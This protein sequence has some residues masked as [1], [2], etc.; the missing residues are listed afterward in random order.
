[1][2]KFLVLILLFAA[3][4]S[5]AQNSLYTKDTL[6]VNPV[7]RQRVKS[8]TIIAANQLAADTSQVSYLLSY[9]NQIIVNP[10]GGWISTMTY[11]VTSNP[12]IN[13][14]SP[15]DAIQF[16]VNSNM[17]K[18]ARA[19]GNILPTVPAEGDSSSNSLIDR[20]RN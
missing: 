20:I 14:D 5:E 4:K 8:A 19:Y 6:A 13:Y 17:D 18:C 3:I 11:Q 10:D 2:K 7:F 1:M 16:T 9:C 12:V 15:D